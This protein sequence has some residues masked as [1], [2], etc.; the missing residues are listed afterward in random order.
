[1]NS[2]KWYVG[3]KLVKARPIPRV[4]INDDGKKEDGYQV[5]Y[6][7]KYL[8]WS[9]KEAFEDAYNHVFDLPFY[10]ALYLLV[11]GKA[12]RIHRHSVCEEINLSPSKKSLVRKKYFAND[13]PWLP[14]Q[15]D[16]FA[17]DWVAY[18]K[19]DA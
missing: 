17:T 4:Q 13:I 2:F 5:E 19:G 8:S 1:M 15:E 12:N 16:I 9:P 11:T 7:D 14:T 6:P 3:C 18:L 10:S